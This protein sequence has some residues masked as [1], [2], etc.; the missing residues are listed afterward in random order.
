MFLNRT[1]L[2]NESQINLLVPD[3]DAA[4]ILSSTAEEMSFTDQIVQNHPFLEEGRE[5]F[6][7]LE[8]M[9]RRNCSL[10]SERKLPSHTCS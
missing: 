5:N 4:E 9:E 3:E 10:S 6:L 1:R 8:R 7:G 2:A